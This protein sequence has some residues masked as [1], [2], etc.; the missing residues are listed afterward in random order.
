MSNK[1]QHRFKKQQLR[2]LNWT[3][4]NFTITLELFMTWKNVDTEA[5]K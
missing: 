1:S 2:S 3:H 4:W 5:D